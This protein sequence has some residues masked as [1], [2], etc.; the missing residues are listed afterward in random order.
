VR[1]HAIP[2]GAGG[3]LDAQLD[4]RG[5]PLGGEPHIGHSHDAQPRVAL[6]VLLLD[7]ERGV[8]ARRDDGGARHLLAIEDR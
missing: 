1:E 3:R 2:I 5:E 4:R 6:D 8:D 7:R